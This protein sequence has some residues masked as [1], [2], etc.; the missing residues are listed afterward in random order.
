MK[1]HRFRVRS[2]AHG[3]K[4]INLLQHK[5]APR[6][7]VAL[8]ESDY[9]AIIAEARTLQTPAAAIVRKAVRYYL[10]R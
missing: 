7:S 2:P 3:G 4:R 10:E 5:V 1:A 9:A 6:I 8:E